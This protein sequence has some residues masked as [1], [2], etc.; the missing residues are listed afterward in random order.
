MGAQILDGK[1]IAERVRSEVK[2]RAEAFE[3][4]HGR[5][6][7]LE[8]VL[9]GDD[10]GSHVY[11]NSKEK[12]SASLGMRGLVHRLPEETT[13]TELLAK[14]A[15]LNVDPNVDGIL[16]QLP[17]P[18]DIDSQTVV[19]AVDPRKDVDGLHP[20]NLGLLASRGVGLRACTP[21]GCLRL[22]AETGV[23]LSGKRAI[24]I[25]RSNLV[26]KP[27]A[28][29]LLEQNCTVTMAHSR[30]NDLDMRVAESDI[31]VAAAGV[32][33]LVKGSW[34]KQGAVVIDV[35]SHRLPENKVVGDVEFALAKERA[36]WITPVPGGVGPMTIAMLM[37]NTIEAAERNAH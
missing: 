34:I 6:A 32:P 26:G 28:L 24:V 21:A 16:V 27:L 4:R 22:L 13:Q 12:T 9:V 25:G 19:H 5:K 11:V 30:T 36:S 37:Q 20:M 14:V 7:G 23:P 17:L 8:V 29:M 35:G 2:V 1:L 3:K 31:V 15:S 18:K 10:P 33:E